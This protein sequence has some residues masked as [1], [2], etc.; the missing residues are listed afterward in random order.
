ML[1]ESKLLPRRI[2]IF[3]LDG[4]ITISLG[5]RYRCYLEAVE[6]IRPA[7][8]EAMERRQKAD[9]RRALRLLEPISKEEF[10]RVYPT[11]SNISELLP[12]EVVPP[13]DQRNPGEDILAQIFSNTFHRRLQAYTDEQLSWDVVPEENK[14]AI[15]ALLKLFSGSI[16][17]YRSMEKP[18][19]LKQLRA[20]GLVNDGNGVSEMFNEIDVNLCGGNGLSSRRA[21]VAFIR[22][23]YDPLIK[24]Q[25]AIGA[26]PIMVGDSE[27]D[28]HVALELG[29]LFVGITTGGETCEARFR[30]VFSKARQ[31]GREFP[32]PWLFPGLG[33]PKCLEFFQKQAEEYADLLARHSGTAGVHN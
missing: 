2:V 11:L 17:S 15:A 33:D 3:D 19:M 27:G 23:W 26:L 28:F 31:A 20:L 30:E 10:F 29:M 25:Q 18:R 5:R 32:E 6:T 13:T 1:R 4:T 7:W 9:G 14:R 21:K 8:D 16:V 24:A 22:Q 12:R